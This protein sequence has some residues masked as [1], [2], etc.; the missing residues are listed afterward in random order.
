MFKKLFVV[1]GLGLLSVGCTNTVV[2]PQDVETIKMSSENAQAISGKVQTY[3][4]IVATLPTGEEQD[5]TTWVKKWWSE[6]VKAWTA[7]S[8]WAQGQPATTPAQP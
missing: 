3:T 5:V 1:V 6:D 7:L 8:N 4:K 2:K